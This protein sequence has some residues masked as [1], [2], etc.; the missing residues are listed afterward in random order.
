MKDD[1]L[2]IIKSRGFWRINFE[3]LVYQEKL[4]KL[5]DC[6]DIVEKNSVPRRT[7]DSTGIEAGSNFYQAWTD[8]CEFKEFWRMY[9]SGQFLHYFGLREDWSE[10]HHWGRA[11]EKAA[12]RKPTL[13]IIGELIYQVTEIYEFLSRL[14]RS[15]IYDEGVRV[16]I[17]LNNMKDR[18]LVVVDPMRAPLLNTYKTS[19][20]KIEISKQ[21]SQ[22]IILARSEELAFETIL[23]ILERFEWHNPPIDVFKRDQEILLSGKFGFGASAR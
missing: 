19:M 12:E 13:N 10:I 3:P 16:S 1:I 5:A 4:A 21:Y 22:E 6:K 2:Q 20:E 15:G 14:T 8:W 9:Q 7:E 23:H 18:K 11:T 17:A